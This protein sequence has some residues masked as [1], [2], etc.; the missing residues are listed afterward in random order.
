MI[1]FQKTPILKVFANFQTEPFLTLRS[2]PKKVSK[3]R[4]PDIVVM[5][6]VRKLVFTTNIQPACLPM[7]HQSSNFAL[8]CSTSGWGSTFKARLCDITEEPSKYVLYSDELKEAEVFIKEVD[9]CERAFK[10]SGK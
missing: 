1:A 4:K 7:P 2:K 10:D 3:S 5:Q 8:N 9:T 6:F